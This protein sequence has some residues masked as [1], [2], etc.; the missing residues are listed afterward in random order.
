MFR[1]GESDLIVIQ[2]ELQ[3]SW[4]EMEVMSIRGRKC[5]SGSFLHFCKRRQHC[6]V[7]DAPLLGLRKTRNGRIIICDECVS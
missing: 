3:S 4:I 6:I 1:P 7:A 2:Q 5:R